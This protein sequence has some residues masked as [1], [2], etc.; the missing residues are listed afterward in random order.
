MGVLRP[1]PT[2]TCLNHYPS[3]EALSFA[4]FSVI[5][6]TDRN[7]NIVSAKVLANPAR[8]HDSA[9]ACQA[10]NDS[11]A[12]AVA[13]DAAVSLWRFVVNIVDKQIFP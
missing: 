5:H 7:E 11:G 9:A 12:P 10:A 13:L 3:G 1:F 4:D 6:Y 2:I 8:F